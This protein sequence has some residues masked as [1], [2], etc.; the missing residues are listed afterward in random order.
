MASCLLRLPDDMLLCIADC[1]MERFLSHVCHRLWALLQYRVVEFP[2]TQERA[3]AVKTHA[4][5]L[6]RGYSLLHDAWAG[7]EW[8]WPWGAG[9]WHWGDGDWEWGRGE[10]IWENWKWSC[11]TPI[12]NVELSVLSA[13]RMSCILRHVDLHVD[14]SVTDAALQA[15]AGL[16]T[17][18]SLLSIKLRLGSCPCDVICAMTSPHSSAA[19]SLRY[20][21]LS[22]GGLTDIEVQAFAELWNLP[23]LQQVSRV[24][25]TSE[26]WRAC[27]LRLLCAVCFVLCV[28]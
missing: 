22:S 25:S 5:L 6:R 28:L 10:W 2:L 15:I 26:D 1:V 24:C 20:V 16:I 9:G 13:L 11:F 7:P 27:P 4:V 17:T 14:P 23:C 19:K 21:D 3:N 8:H 12:P 18:T